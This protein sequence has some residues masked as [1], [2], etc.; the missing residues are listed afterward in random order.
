MRIAH[1]ALLLLVLAASGCRLAPPG[2]CDRDGDCIAGQHCVEEVCAPDARSALFASCVV[3]RDCNT[4]AQCQRNVCVLAP[5][6]CAESL[7][8]QAW[9]GCEANACR[10]LAGRCDTLSDCARWEVCDATHTC[11]VA[12]G[13]CAPATAATDC[14]S[15][16]VCAPTHFCATAPGACATQ[17]DC[18]T[19]QVCTAH[20]CVAQPS[21]PAL[22]P[23]AVQLV[24]TLRPG[25]PGLAAVAALGAPGIKLVG[26]AAGDAACGARIGSTGQ[27]VYAPGPATLATLV[28]DPFLWSLTWAYPATP[29]ANDVALPLPG[30]EAAPAVSAVMQPGTDAVLYAC[31]TLDY[32]DAGGTRLVSGHPLLAWNA[33]D[34]KLAG[35]PDMTVAPTLLDAT[36]TPIPLTGAALIDGDRLV[37]WRATASGFRVVRAWGAGPALDTLDVFEIDGSGAVVLLPAPPLLPAEVTE[38]SAPVLDAAGAVYQLCRTAAADVVVKRTPG[39]AAEVLYDE[40]TLPPAAASLLD[41]VVRVDAASCLVTGP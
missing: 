30:C 40:A 9:E 6:A 24:G 11:V 3:D 1:A 34:L 39:G 38:A 14:A 32:R 36:G 17:D 33:A 37:A 12:P 27:L 15:W 28:A 23:A 31:G 20:A 29:H 21:P 10:P 19:D 8:C 35:T 5:G 18:P 25:S 41:E 26:L 13:R 2:S 4:F 22:D 16:Q 7:D